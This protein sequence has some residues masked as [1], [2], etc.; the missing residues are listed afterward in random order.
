MSAHSQ[1]NTNRQLADAFKKGSYASVNLL[2]YPLTNM[3]AG[4]ELLSGRH[5][6]N[7]SYFLLTGRTAIASAS[8]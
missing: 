7:D 3:T 8:L 2:D 6:N 5:E 4:A 1:S